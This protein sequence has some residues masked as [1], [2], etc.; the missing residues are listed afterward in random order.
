MLER[1]PDNASLGIFYIEYIAEDLINLRLRKLPVSNKAAIDT[2]LHGFIPL[3]RFLI[4]FFFS[5]TTNGITALAPLS[6][7]NPIVAGA[8]WEKVFAITSAHPGA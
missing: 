8:Y 4:I 1:V 7:I 6:I 5:S 2:R 3:S